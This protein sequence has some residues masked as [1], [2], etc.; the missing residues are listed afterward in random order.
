MQYAVTADEIATGAVGSDEI[1]VGA[2]GSSEILDLSIDTIDLKNASVTSDKLSTTGV[3]AGSYNQANITVDSQGRI[4]S[5]TTGT[6]SSALPR[7]YISG[8]NIAKVDATTVSVSDGIARS[9]DNT[10][11]LTLTGT[12]GLTNID[13]TSNTGLNS[14]ETLPVSD[15]ASWYLNL[16]C[17]RWNKHRSKSCKRIFSTSWIQR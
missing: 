6:V 9:S 11:D 5:A 7:S 15:V 12:G 10:T 4:T 2:V 17:Y 14:V 16:A 1:A 8:L 3:T 13:F